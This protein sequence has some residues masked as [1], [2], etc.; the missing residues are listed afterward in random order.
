MLLTENNQFFTPCLV[1]SCHFPIPGESGGTSLGTQK[2]PVNE[3]S[4]FVRLNSAS[5]DL[6]ASCESN[7]PV[8][9]T[10][11][12]DAPANIHHNKNHFMIFP[13]S[14]IRFSFLV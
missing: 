7:G 2:P 10:P 4:P 3:M 13:P 14:E 6:H 8:D 1:I 12:C 11:N 5:A 9:A